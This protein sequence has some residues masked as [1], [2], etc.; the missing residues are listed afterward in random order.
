MQIN[1]KSVRRLHETTICSRNW[2]FKGE[3]GY[4]SYLL[5]LHDKLLLKSVIR[6]DFL[7][8]PPLQSKALVLAQ[9]MDKGMLFQQNYGLLEPHMPF[10]A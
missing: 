5:V 8:P 4:S 7:T 6:V 1:Y 10:A 2:S 3:G 9:L